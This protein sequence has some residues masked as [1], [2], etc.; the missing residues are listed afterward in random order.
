MGVRLALATASAPPLYEALLKNHGIYDCFDA[1]VSPM[2]GLRDKRHPDMYLLAARRLDVMPEDCVVFEDILAGVR[3]AK[4]AG[5][6]VC[7]VCD[8]FGR[9]SGP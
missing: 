8:R 5:I 2:D 4:A 3:S 9:P 1:F 6:R 7:G